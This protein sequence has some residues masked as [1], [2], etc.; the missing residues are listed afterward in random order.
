[1]TARPRLVPP[2][3]ECGAASA[4]G[5]TTP[6]MLSCAAAALLSQPTSAHREAQC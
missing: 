3:S 4:L 5:I 6:S 2:C 1:M